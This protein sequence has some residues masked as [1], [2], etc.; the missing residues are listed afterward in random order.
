MI[1]LPPGWTPPPDLAEQIDRLLHKPR[2]APPLAPAELPAPK[3]DANGVRTREAGPPISGKH[4]K[5]R[6]RSDG[7]G[8]GPLAR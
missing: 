7:H 2:P 6:R 8:R 4:R 5:I 3:I 1:D